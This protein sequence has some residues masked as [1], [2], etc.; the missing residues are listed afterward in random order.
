M[1]YIYAPSGRNSINIQSVAWWPRE[2]ETNRKLYIYCGESETPDTSCIHI[3]QRMHSLHIESIGVGAQHIGVLCFDLWD[4]HGL[5]M[6][7]YVC[8]LKLRQYIQAYVIKSYSLHAVQR[9]L[10]LSLWSASGRNNEVTSLAAAVSCHWSVRARVGRLRTLITGQHGLSRFRGV[11]S[12]RSCTYMKYRY[13][14][15]SG[16]KRPRVLVVHRSLTKF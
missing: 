1:A 4:L 16:V 3:E 12:G 8:S 11:I 6:L 5:Y 13:R 9:F 14:N 10:Y 2:T 7:L 15:V